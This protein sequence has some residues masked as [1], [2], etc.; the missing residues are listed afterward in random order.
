MTDRRS[1]KDKHNLRVSITAPSYK[2]VEYFSTINLSVSLLNNSSRKLLV[3]SLTLRFQS[4]ANVSAIYVEQPCG[5]EIQPDGVKDQQVTICPTPEYLTYTNTFDIMVNYRLF[6][7]KGLKG[8]YPEIHN[9]PFYLI[10]NNS[11]AKLGQIFISFK[12][13]EDLKLARILE[14]LAFRAGFSPYL[15]I[16][17]K[18]T[19][20]PLW[21]KIEPAIKDSVAAFI[22][23]TKHTQ[24]G[25]GVE[26][27][28]E[29]CGKWKVPELLLI[30]ND[31]PLPEGYSETVEH[32]RFDP[33]DATSAFCEAL[34]SRRR[35][36]FKSK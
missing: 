17:D 18:Q 1:D 11:K 30:E 5:W 9:G 22:I 31:I 34:I 3:E 32:Q 36:I 33:E 14:R 24:W 28:I 6:D 12:Q 23:W 16:R 25:D 27:E 8:P 10:I 21:E 19:G 4:D 13:N 35:M 7:N 15:A 29:L 26:R 2:E 20:A